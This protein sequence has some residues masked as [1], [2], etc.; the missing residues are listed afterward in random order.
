MKVFDVISEAKL[1]E[2]YI[3][4]GDQQE[5]ISADRA[6]E[7]AISRNARFRPWGTDESEWTYN[8]QNMKAL[9]EEAILIYGN[10][11]SG[12]RSGHSLEALVSALVNYWNGPGAQEKANI[13]NMMR[14]IS[15][16]SNPK[17][18]KN[19]ALGMMLNSIVMSFN[20]AKYVLDRANAPEDEDGNTEDPSVADRRGT[21]VPPGTDDFPEGY[22]IRML[23]S[24]R[25]QL[26]GPNNQKIGDDI[27]GGGN[28]SLVAISR[29]R[30]H[31]A[32]NN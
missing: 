9:A 26:W 5:F 3:E 2:F 31:A 18:K 16:Q 22:E 13:S 25:Y 28:L 7:L 11:Y 19:E 32:Q 24:N 8:S 17:I 21:P 12:S 10:H 14:V 29:A 4:G 23:A 6:E 20:S 1:D 15:E 30:Q 27:T